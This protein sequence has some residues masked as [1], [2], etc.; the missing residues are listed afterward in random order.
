MGNHHVYRKAHEISNEGHGLTIAVTVSHSMISDRAS[1]L[2]RVLN[3]EQK[4]LE[5]MLVALK[6][7]VWC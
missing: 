7:G 4:A 1:R 6:D 5:E 2:G 3:M